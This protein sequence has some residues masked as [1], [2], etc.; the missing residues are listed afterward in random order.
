MGPR[1]HGRAARPPRGGDRGVVPRDARA[2]AVRAA[3]AQG[4]LQRRTRTAS[5][6]IQQ[7]AHDANLLFYGSEEAQEG[8]EAYKEKRRPDFSQFP[9][10]GRDAAACAS[11]SWP[12]ALR[13]LPAAVA[14][15]L[16]GT[17]L[18]ITDG[19]F[20]ARRVRRGAARRDLHPGRDEPLERLLRRAARR[21]HRGPPRPRARDRRRARA[22][23]A[24]PH[25]D[26]RDA[27][28]LAVLVRRLPRGGRRAG[29]CCSSASASILAGVLYTG[30]PRPYGYEGLGEVF[31]F[32]F[33]GVVAVTGSYVRAARALAVGGVR[34]RRA[35]SAC[36]PSAILV[37]NN[38]RDLETD[39][40]AGKRRSPCASGASARATLFAA[41]V[42]GAFLAAPLPWI[43]G[44]RRAGPVAAAAVARRCRSRSGSCAPCART[45]TARRSTTRWPAP[46]MLQLAFC[47]LLC[48]GHPREL[49]GRARGRRRRG[50]TLRFRRPLRTALRRAARARAAASC[51][52][53]RRGRRPGPRR[54]GAAGALRRRARSRTHGERA[55]GLRSRSCASA[56]GTLGGASCSTRAARPPTCPRRSPRSTSRCGTAPGGARAARSPSCSPTSP[57]DEVPVN[58]TIGALDRAGAAT[59]AADAAAA[60]F[61][62]VKV[63]V[64]VGDDAGPRRRRARG[65]RP[66]DGAAPRRQ[67]RV[68]RRGGGARRSRRS[69]RPG[70]SSSRSRSTASR[71][72]ARCASACRCGSRW[73]RRP[74]SPARSPRPPP[75]PS[76]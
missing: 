28:A 56:D 66:D 3:A 5:P 23:A 11:G 2:L 1:Q 30:G 8:R 40:R 48:A 69:R 65:G 24:G 41:M 67:R 20:R 71:R 31:V 64:G 52:S 32:L 60:G 29:S 22:A 75:T 61:G 68:G 19:D 46:G 38:V 72:C 4:E 62:C 7:L 53:T 33:F 6:G 18:A 35:R 70:S 36:S 43:A 50:V 59:A 55:R 17:A 26:V 45:P 21:R 51:G 74:P 12:R 14:P 76:A 25:R 49:T 47:V 27:S 63:K 9:Q 10:A 34:A 13:T 44:S 15:V 16:V 42:Y 37:V 58:A 39:R 73:T 54:G 57:L